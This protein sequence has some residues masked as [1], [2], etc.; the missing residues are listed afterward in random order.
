MN[1][2]RRGLY[3]LLAVAVLVAAT[4]VAALAQEDRQPPGRDDPI[5]SDEARSDSF[6][7]AKAHVTKQIERRLD[8]LDRL[9]GKIEGARHLT[10]SHAASL[11]RDIGAAREV[12]RAGL[13]SVQA[14][15]TPEELREVAPPI[16][17]E[18]LVFALLAPKSHEVI[19]SDA[20]V[21]ATQRFADFAAKLQE[22]LDR[23]ADETDIDT[24][25][26]QA[27]LDEMVRLINAA[28]AAGE[29]VAE[30]VIG[31]QP[32]D[33]PDPAQSMLREGRA[34]LK[35]ARGSL[36]EARGLAREVLAFIR[37]ASGRLDG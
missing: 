9:T 2:L 30:N 19:A 6:E 31:L 36:R 33:W 16:F 37:A 12:L 10:E 3:G 14:V 1:D 24:T 11:L 13:A 18:T 8:A 17:E 5:V 28:A 21:A 29:P 27:D 7:R 34:S 4:P 25:E 15:T 32:S 26:A 20:V 35:A 22:A 23:L